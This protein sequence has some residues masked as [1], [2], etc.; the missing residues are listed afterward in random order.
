[1]ART[2]NET[3]HTTKRN[4]ILNTAMRLIYTKGY[5]QMTIQ[6]ILDT[7][8]ISRGALYHY[9]D[10][11]QTLVE[12]LIERSAIEV[13]VSLL[14]IFENPTLTSIQKIQGYFD[15]STRWKAQQQELLIGAL[16]N[17]YS[18][19]NAIM[20]QKLTTKSVKYM[21]RL[22]EPV[23]RQGIEEGVMKTR[24][25]AEVAHIF[26]DLTVD[27]SDRLIEL[28]FSSEPDSF[29][30]AQVFLDA[31]FDTIERALGA[32]AGSFEI[33]DV[34]LFKDWF[35]VKKPGPAS[36]AETLES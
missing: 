9:F 24:F 2:V 8:H 29:Q 30:R 19:E 22:L 21:A 11:K 5:E 35:V 3:E 23:I 1:M 12:E 27:L 10:S 15:Y 13:E 7:L 18:D 32:P 6:T 36:D 28:M 14:S 34:G 16:Q 26:A 31:Y 25:P 20:R 4:D 33:V 17:W